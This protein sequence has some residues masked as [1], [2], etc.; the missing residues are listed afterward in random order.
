[1][2]G[3]ID[4]IEVRVLDAS[5][6]GDSSVIE[7]IVGIMNRAYATA[8]KALW[9]REVG[10]TTS[11]EAGGWV[12]AGRLAVAEHSGRIVGAVCIE[13][14]E[15]ATG[16]FGALSVDPDQQGRGIASALLSF[17]E[18]HLRSA[19]ATE[20]EIE[21]LV[22]VDPEPHSSRLL[23]WYGSVGYVE[24]HRRRLADFDARAVEDALLDIDV[25]VLRKQLG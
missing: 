19:G 23:A 10:R 9:N 15:Q 12:A 20:I 17:T 13:M 22:P 1:M 7:T 21:V 4:D 6:A 5:A 3:V 11:E 18:Q 25:A 16:W 8:E 24:T 14:R 2:T